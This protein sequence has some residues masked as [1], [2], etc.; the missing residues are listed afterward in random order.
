MNRLFSFSLLSSLFFVACGP[1][2][3]C[4]TKIESIDSDGNKSSEQNVSS[5]MVLAERGPVF[6]ADV[7]DAKGMKATKV[8]L[9][10]S[11]RYR[12]EKKPTFPLHLENG[13]IDLNRD[14]K[15]D[16][17]DIELDINMSSYSL[18]ISPLTTVVGDSKERMKQLGDYL[19]ITEDEILNR[20]PSEASVNAVVLSNACYKAIKSGYSFGSEEFNRTVDEVKTIYQENFIEVKDSK[21]LA[22]VLEERVVVKSAVKVNENR[23]SIKDN[24]STTDTKTLT[25]DDFSYVYKTSDSIET[26]WSIPIEIQLK[27]TVKD[28]AIAVGFS[29]EGSSSNGTMLISG[30]DITN[31]SITRIGSVAMVGEKSTGSKGSV[32]YGA[33]HSMTQNSLAIIQGDTLLINM[34]YIINNQTVVSQS[35]F[36]KVSKTNITIYISNLDVGG[37]NIGEISIESDADDG[38]YQFPTTTQSIS[39]VIEIKGEKK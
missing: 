37:S 32:T 8:N 2:G 18:V 4:G 35:S 13:V 1:S 26:I 3:G 23:T 20:V 16:E 10:Y 17:N 36:R 30:V 15:I 24:S 5:Y 22:R 11:N 34:G 27:Q 7:S 21:E 29:K 31:N 14:N 19:S 38:I 12:F 6:L 9:G 25:N 39:G 28:V 33:G